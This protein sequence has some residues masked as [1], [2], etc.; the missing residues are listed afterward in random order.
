MLSFN[1]PKPIKGLDALSHDNEDMSRIGEGMSRVAAGRSETT[2]QGWRWARD[3]HVE[4]TT[5]GNG[6]GRR[7]THLLLPSSASS[8]SYSSFLLPPSCSFLLPRPP[9]PSRQD[10]GATRAGVAGSSA[11]GGCGAVTAQGPVLRGSP[12]HSEDTPAWLGTTVVGGEGAALE[13]EGRVGRVVFPK[14]Q[15][16][17][18]SE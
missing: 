18:G 14:V 12:A 6:T 10:R 2:G 4:K 1:S 7:S 16:V 3:G 9:S 5:T 8:P 15:F 13:I 17:W 11:S